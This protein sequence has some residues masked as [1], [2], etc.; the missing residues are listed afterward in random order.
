M[1]SKYFL[2]A[3]LPLLILIGLCA[4][5][6]EKTPAKKAS[7]P[8]TSIPDSKEKETSGT[9]ASKTSDSESELADEGTYDPANVKAAKSLIAKVSDADLKEVDAT[10]LFKINCSICHG[11]KGN[12]QVNGAK[13]LTKITSNQSQK[14][15]RIMFG[16]NLMTPYKDILSEA[17]IVALANHVASLKK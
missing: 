3:F 14:V 10:K 5:G 16:K 4:C 12:M 6:G 2:Q 7:K 1:Q 13:D 17:E 8:A 15:A 9:E 11:T